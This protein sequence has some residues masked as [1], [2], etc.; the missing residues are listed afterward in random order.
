MDHF[1]QLDEVDYLLRQFHVEHARWV[2]EEN[3]DIFVDF[4][5]HDGARGETLLWAVLQSSENLGMFHAGRGVDSELEAALDAR[6][7]GLP[8]KRDWFA[9][10]RNSSIPVIGIF[11]IWPHVRS[12]LLRSRRPFINAREF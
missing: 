4:D 11:E 12:P 5:L 6:V 10:D 8:D 3:A 9:S 7:V 2:G 1:P